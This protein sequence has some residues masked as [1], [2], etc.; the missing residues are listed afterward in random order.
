M[1]GPGELV[2]LLEDEDRRALEEIGTTRQGGRGD[3]VLFEGQVADKV[4]V[5]LRGRVKVV[6]SASSGDQTLLDFRGPGALM[7]EQALVDGSPR[8]AT[9]VAVEPVE[10]LVVAASAFRAFVERRPRVAFALLAML[11]VRLR[12]SNRRL[13]QF[14]AADTLGRVSGR[15]LELC[16]EHGEPGDNGAVTITLPLT[17]EELASWT[18]A[19]LESTAKALRTMRDLGW[20]ATGRRAIAV[21]DI[22]A[23][24]ARSA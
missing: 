1:A 21:H 17:Q 13:A 3:V 24:R 18:G 12:D 19:S 11:S 10:Y 2:A 6:T 7:G 22:D 14:A 8:S 9:V 23:M 16:E 20:I 4:V 15:L 5:L